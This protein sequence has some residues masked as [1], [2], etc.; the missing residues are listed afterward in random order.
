MLIL[1]VLMIA[2]FI[3][4]SKESIRLSYAKFTELL[5]AFYVFSCCFVRFNIPVYTLPYEHQYGSLG[6][7]VRIEMYH[8]MIFVLLWVISQRKNITFTPIKPMPI[9]VLAFYLIYTILNPFNVVKSSSFVAINYVLTYLVFLYLLTTCC[10]IE[11]IIKGV[12]RGFAATL[13]LH[14]LLLLAYTVSGSSFVV[15][16]FNSDAV[17]RRGASPATFGHP[18]ALGAYASFYMMFFS[19]C[20]LTKFRMKP[21]CIYAVLS[22]IVVYMSASRSALLA[23]AFAV[24]VLVVMYVFRRYSLF[25]IKILFKGVLP[26]GV[27]LLLLYNFTPLANL[28]GSTS[29]ADDM[30][31]ARYMHYYCAYEI[32]N[33]HPL[34]GVGLNSH[35]KYLQDNS[36]LV[37]IETMFEG[38]DIWLPED[39]MFHNPIHNIWLIF[40]TE[41]GI[42]GVIPIL[43]FVIYT[44]VSFKKKIR[45]SVS[46]YYNIAVITGLGIL[47]CM[48]VHGNSD[49]AL[50]TPAMLNI[51]I[52]FFFLA[53]TS[54]YAL[55]QSDDERY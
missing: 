4:L 48:I 27:I 22:V 38:S 40:L 28:F 30:V 29:D 42:I 17:R 10:S 46:L 50:Y 51:S 25:N 1:A 26:V 16:L 12:Y 54:K 8:I 53:A 49:W 14:L 21:S 2:L 39:F 18:N 36:A 52:M 20:V 41:F 34:V 15:T 47:S 23:C 9:I 45:D 37:D 32:F 11:T 55:E 3:W 19:A 5:V 43:S 24:V 31:L 7:S 6:M 13:V 33:D 35:L 44:F